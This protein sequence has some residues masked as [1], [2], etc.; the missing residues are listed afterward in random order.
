MATDFLHPQ[1]SLTV[2]QATQRDA[3]FYKCTAKTLGSDSKTTY[4]HIY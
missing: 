3:G 2:Q 1:G 4:V